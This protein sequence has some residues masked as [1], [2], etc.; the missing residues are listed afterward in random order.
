MFRSVHFVSAFF[1]ATQFFFTLCFI[2]TLFAIILIVMYLLCVNEYYRVS[3]LRWTGIVLIVAG[4]FKKCRGQSKASITN[5]CNDDR[6]SY[7]SVEME[8]QAN[9]KAIYS[10]EVARILSQHI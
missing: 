9:L 1:V 8:N 7:A 5:Y 6:L 3:V 10:W 4:K 2:G